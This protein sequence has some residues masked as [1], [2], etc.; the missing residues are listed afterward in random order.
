VVTAVK[1]LSPKTH[2]IAV[3]LLSL[4]DQIRGYGP[5]KEASVAKAKTRY[6]QLA[7]DIVDPPPLAAP[8]IAA[9]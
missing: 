9:E 4:P 5:V 1:L 2:D 3:E 8:R 7:K 6:E